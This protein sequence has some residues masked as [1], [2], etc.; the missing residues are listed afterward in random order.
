MVVSGRGFSALFVCLCVCFSAQYLKNNATRITKL[1]VKMFHDGS[2]KPIYFGVEKSKIKVT[3][4]TLVSAGFFQLCLVLTFTMLETQPSF[5]LTVGI[6][7]IFY[8]CPA[9]LKVGYV[10]WWMLYGQPSS[11]LITFDYVIA[12][13][14]IGCDVIVTSS[15]RRWSLLS[16]S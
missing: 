2:W 15:W 1:D 16:T 4:C 9:S 7:F 6:S 8:L 13:P 3:S 12:L 5:K 11:C 10:V 14:R